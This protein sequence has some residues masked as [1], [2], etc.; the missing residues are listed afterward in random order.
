L[1][2]EEPEH[3]RWKVHGR[4]TIY[5]SD[6]VNVYLD[7]VELPDGTH[8]DHH[9]LT[10]PKAS[11][12]AIV[13]NAA[14]DHVL[15]IWR[16]RFI[17]DK[18]GWEVPAGWVEPGEDPKASIRREIVEE[19][20]YEVDRI[21]PLV[22]Y[23]A[24]PGLST[25]HFNCWSATGAKRISEPTD[26]SESTVVQWHSRARIATLVQ[27]GQLSD[28]PSITALLAWLAYS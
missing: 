8:I 7:D 4:R 19:T 28:G 6:W 13:L 25:M 26:P 2:P 18:W 5:E 24:I 16:H 11:Q 17:T 14:R 23:D 12:T 15:L 9:V 10:M 20:G 1:H 21:E 27:E 3:A 22:D